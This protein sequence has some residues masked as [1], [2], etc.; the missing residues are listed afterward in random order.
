MNA[1]SRQLN[2]VPQITRY[3]LHAV[4]GDSIY[5]AR[6]VRAAVP[7][8]I[9]EQNIASCRCIIRG[10][11]EPAPRRRQQRSAGAC[12]RDDAL[13][14]LGITQAERN[15]HRA[16]VAV[17][18][19]IPLTVPGDSFHFPAVGNNVVFCTLGIAK[20]AAGN[21]KNIFRPGSGERHPGQG[22]FPHGWALHIRIR[23]GIAGQ[24]MLVFRYLTNQDIRI[25]FVRVDMGIF[26]GFRKLADQ[27]TLGFVAFRPV[28][29]STLALGHTADIGCHAPITLR[30]VR[31]GAL[32]LGFSADIGFHSFVT[33]VGM[34]V[35]LRFVSTGKLLFGLNTFI[36][37]YMTGIFRQTAYQA[38]SDGGAAV[39][40][41][42]ARGLF[43][44]A[45]QYLPFLITVL[46]MN[47]GS[48]YRLY[49]IVLLRFIAAN[50]ALFIAFFLMPVR[51]HTA[52]RS[53]LHGNGREHH[54]INGP[55]R[56]NRSQKSRSLMSALFPPAGRYV[57]VHIWRKDLFHIGSSLSLFQRSKIGKGPNP[58]YNFSN[59]LFFRYTAYAGVP[60]ING[61]QPVIAY[62][63]VAA[64][65][66]LIRQFYVTVSQGFFRQIR[67]VQE[68]TVHIDIPCF[69]Y[70]DPLA[71]TGN[72]A[73]H[74]NLISKIKGH[75]IALLEVRALNGDNNISLTKGGRHG[76]TENL[77]NRHPDGRNQNGNGSNNHQSIYRTAQDPTIA[78]FIPLPAQLR[79]Q[80]L[81]R[82]Q[83]PGGHC[84]FFHSVIP[85]PAD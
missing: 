9:Q 58:E 25:A 2:T 72:T 6:A 30:C 35:H 71:R 46:I 32:S 39:V 47:M 15:K 73:L 5:K 52:I 66:H 42:V 63:E 13:G 44:S 80:L 36:R 7:I 10:T 3:N 22:A 60:G 82:R 16:P 19:A 48:S 1:V 74:K 49:S 28:C 85:F 12:R 23:I 55:N 31:V 68:L 57:L 75:K 50:K 64:L 18:V 24:R 20:L 26:C 11:A 21:C 78:S 8:F 4:V 53:L 69:V 45:D 79:R 41:N 83:F 54:R 84:S 51:L 29:M 27:N 40:M 61:S 56:N 33:G 14:H 38:L 17:R 37:V 62:A 43:Q 59:N 34:L 65:R 70:I 76:G 77:Q 67:L 81:Q